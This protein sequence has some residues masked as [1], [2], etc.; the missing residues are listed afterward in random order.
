MHS[1]VWINRIGSLVYAS[2]LAV[3]GADHGVSDEPVLGPTLGTHAVAESIGW[4]MAVPGSR[5]P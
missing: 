1:S 2:I 3:A 5:F 4:E